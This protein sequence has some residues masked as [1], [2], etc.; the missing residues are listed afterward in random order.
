[1]TKEENA[2]GSVLADT[3]R[4]V[5]SPKN[6]T[7][8]KSIADSTIMQDSSSLLRELA[9]D[10]VNRFVKKNKKLMDSLGDSSPFST[11]KEVLKQ[12]KKSL[13]SMTTK[14]YLKKIPFAEQVAQDI[15]EIKKQA[16]EGYIEISQVNRMIYDACKKTLKKEQQRIKN[17]IKKYKNPYPKDIFRWDNDHEIDFSRGRFNK[18][19]YE[20]V[21]NVRKD[22]L[23]EMKE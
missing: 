3:K 2:K 9:K 7:H 19:C 11:D 23:K 5:S 21:E 14:A 13:D 20:I 12:A 6:P 22:I 18:H 16:R 4:N 15:E 17:I 10:Q 8:K 1:M